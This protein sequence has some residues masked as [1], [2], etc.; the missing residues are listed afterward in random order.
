MLYGKEKPNRCMTNQN[1]NTHPTTKMQVFTKRFKN[2]FKNLKMF[3][4][5]Y[6]NRR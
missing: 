3:L 4:Q 2:Y 5:A 6:A 1:T